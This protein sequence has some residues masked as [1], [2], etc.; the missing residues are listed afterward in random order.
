ME[1]LGIVGARGGSKGLPGKNVRPLLGQPLLSY[2]L[3]TAKRCR[4]VTR[5][6][7][8]TD[9]EEYAAV[10][11]K[12]GAD[13]PFLRPAE[14][15]SDTA[16][17]LGYIRHA[18]EW[19]AEHENYRPDLVVRLCPTAPLIRAEDVDR[20]IELVMGDPQAE[21][22]IIMTPS[23]EHPRKVVKL[24]PDGVHVVSYITERGLD[25]APTNR[26]SYAE[27]YNRQSLPI[28]SRRQT[29]LERNSQ[30]G[31]IV[32]FHVVPQDTALDID[33]ELDF[34]I[35]ETLLAERAAARPAP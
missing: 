29:I 30:T 20:C 32:R 18:L 22:A 24:A 14:H 5:V 34:R 11:R 1:V 23:R 2:A 17:E 8:S 6:L 26:Q 35:I 25:V 10:G 19:L 4:H 27:A 9:S 13:T 3:Q 31:D 28:V 16:I 21:S 7:L 33:T 12:Y 15:A